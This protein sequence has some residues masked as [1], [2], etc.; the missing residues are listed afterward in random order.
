MHVAAALAYQH[1][2]LQLP[3]WKP[4]DDSGVSQPFVGLPSQSPK[5]GWHMNPH[6][7]AVHAAV[8]CAGA[9][10]RVPHPPQ[11]P[12]SPRRST[13]QPSAA[14]PLQSA[15]PALHTKVQCPAE[16]AGSAFA[17][18]GQAV[19]QAPQFVTLDCR[20]VSQPSAAVPLQS[21]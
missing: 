6:P 14:F 18:D 17:G 4:L 10:H 20:V 12:G 1:R 2:L 21:P 13:S 15:K 8:A 9:A 5:P 7:P 19:P 11:W 3:Q 16:H